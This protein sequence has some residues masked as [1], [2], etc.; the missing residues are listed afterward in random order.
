[1]CGAIVEAG[2]RLG[3]ATPYNN[4]MLWLVKALEVNY[5]KGN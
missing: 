3:F 1:M 4:A 2:Q 5:Q